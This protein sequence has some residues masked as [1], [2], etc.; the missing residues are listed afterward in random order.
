MIGWRYWWRRLLPWVPWQPCFT[1]GR[2]FWGGLPR[3]WFY[4]VRVLDRTFWRFGRTWEAAWQ[5]YCS[6]KCHDEDES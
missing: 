2:L 6:T 5:D 4:R 1:C 3:W